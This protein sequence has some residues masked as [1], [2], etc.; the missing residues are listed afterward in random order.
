MFELV[1]LGTSASA[2]SVQRGLSSAIVMINEHRFMID[3]GEGTQRQILRAGLGFRRLDKILLTHGHLD[4]ILG[5]GGLASTLGRWETLEELNIYGGAATLAR[6]QVLMEV[7]FGLGQAPH[8]GIT[9]N[10]M[11][12]GLL[13][14]DKHITLSTFPVQHRGPDCFGF[15]FEEK[16]RRPFLP[17]KAQAL[18]IPPGPERRELTAGHA[19]TLPDGRVILPEAVLGEPQRGAK[20]CFIGDVSHTGP[21]HK[22]VADADLLAIE[23]TYMEV[24]KDLAKDHGHITATAA[25]KLARNA[26]VKQLILHHVSRR[27]RTQDILAEAQAIFP[28]TIVAND[29]DLFQVNKSKPVQ[30]KSL[31]HRG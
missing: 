13:F 12:P 17:E 29:L 5:L 20:L 22:M 26:G 4:H 6:V 10:L 24:D 19:I 31:H 16:T 28:Q 27:Y 21:L 8:A 23:A 3:C 14:E 11:E 1:F 18:G 9:L 30:V 7:V 2:P 15:I 25:A